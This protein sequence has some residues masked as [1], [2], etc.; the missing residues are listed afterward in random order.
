M[1][2]QKE[3]DPDQVLGDAM[4]LFWEQGYEATSVEDLV[5]RMGINRFSLYDTFG[6][7]HELFL[8]A[9]DR[10]R[11]QM[12]SGILADLSNSDDGIPAIRRYF[13]SMI[14]HRT[15][16]DGRKACLIVNS[17]ADKATEDR[18][19]RSKCMQNVKMLEA[20]FRR[21]VER[22]RDLGEIDVA[23]DPQQLAEYLTTNAMGLSVLAKADR[24]R[25]RL[26]RNVEMIMGTL[27]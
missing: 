11:K 21:A 3:F 6:S 13:D 12:G 7:K 16:P 5:G 18:A 17:I 24:R 4:E 1:P 19:V 10:Y 8:Q 14:E 2:R 22:A 25:Q 26:V 23:Q 27:V 9:L 15:S 20:A